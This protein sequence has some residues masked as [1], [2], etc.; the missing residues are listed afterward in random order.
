M[1]GR[2]G[3]RVVGEREGERVGERLATSSERVGRSWSE[4]ADGTTCAS[5]S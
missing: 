4:R 3:K 1:G 5:I 2:V